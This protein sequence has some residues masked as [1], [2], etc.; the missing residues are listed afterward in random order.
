MLSKWLKWA[1]DKGDW[2]DPLTEKNDELLGKS[3]H[4]FELREDE[5]D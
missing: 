3:K 5:S 2:L 4:I 1:H